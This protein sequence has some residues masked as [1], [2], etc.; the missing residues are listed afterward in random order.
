[1]LEHN[2][3]NRRILRYVTIYY[4]YEG[5]PLILKMPIMYYVLLKTQTNYPLSYF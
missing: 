4:T 3:Q 5:L 2:L 1:M